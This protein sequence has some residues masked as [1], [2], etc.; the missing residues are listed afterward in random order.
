MHTTS[1]K[2]M[3]EKLPKEALILWEILLAAGFLA[4][5]ILTLIIFEAG[6]LAR[7]LLLT[8]SLVLWIF[9][10]ALYMPLLYRTY[11][12]AL[13]DTHFMVR[14]GIF[15][16]REQWM[17]R[18]HIIYVSRFDTPFTTI[19]RVSALLFTASGA[20]LLLPSIG[21]ARAKELELALVR[22]KGASGL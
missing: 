1:P 11:R 14:R 10:G 13:T 4:V 20:R 19:L 9:F 5:L 17:E 7:V 21:L 8:L 6:A 15:F 22:G 12:F 16:L 18:R 2:P 3:E